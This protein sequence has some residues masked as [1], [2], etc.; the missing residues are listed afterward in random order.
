MAPADSHLEKFRYWSQ[1]R[2]SWVKNFGGPRGEKGYSQLQVVFRASG[3][4]G[5]TSYTY[6]FTDDAAGQQAFDLMAAAESPGEIV[7][8]HLIRPRVTVGKT[9]EE[10]AV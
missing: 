5:R 7:H 3:N 2:Y 4:K 8:S 1:R 10:P 9:V 6:F